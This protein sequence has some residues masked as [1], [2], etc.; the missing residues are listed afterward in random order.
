MS[1]HQDK[2]WACDGLMWPHSNRKEESSDLAESS[3]TSTA[4]WLVRPI[5]GDAVQWAAI[6]P[7]WPHLSSGLHLAMESLYITS[8][9]TLQPCAAPRPSE[10]VSSHEDT[11]TLLCAWTRTET[12][13]CTFSSQVQSQTTLSS[14]F[15][16]WGGGSP[17]QVPSKMWIQ[18][19][20]TLCQAGP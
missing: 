3:L 16:Y 7:I 17:D 12:L 20:H 14:L 19:V 1:L 6:Y 10:P 9:L 2:I 5:P 13:L 15:C 8:P 18:F 4:A 11:H